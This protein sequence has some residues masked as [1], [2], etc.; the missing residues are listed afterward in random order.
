MNDQMVIATAVAPVHREPSFNS[1]M[2]TQGLMWEKVE[3]IGEEKLWFHIRQE[4]GYIGWIYT[5]YLLENSESFDYWVT[6]K[7]RFVPF[8]HTEVKNRDSR[9][10]SFGTKVPVLE[11]NTNYIS[12]TLPGQITGKIPAQIVKAKKSRVQLCDLVKSLLGTPYI[13]GGKSAFGFDCSGFV[14]LVLNT[15][16]ISIARDTGKQVKSARLQEINKDEAKPG[17]LVFFA[18]NKQINHVGFSL[19]EGKIIHCSGE[20]KIESINE[21]DAGFNQYLSQS[22]FKTCSISDKVVG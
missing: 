11:E 13:W 9:L 1:E 16:G 4:D 19:G 3:I 14:Q 8:T 7:D 5:F 22:I 12:I 20:V 21:G 15:I 2:T 18:E 10:L 6:L 17:D